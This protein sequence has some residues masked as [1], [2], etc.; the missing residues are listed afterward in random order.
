MYISPTERCHSM[1]TPQTKKLKYTHAQTKKKKRN[2]FTHTH[3][4]IASPPRH[5]I[6][7]RVTNFCKM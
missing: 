3:A 2:A 6:I 5:G 7:M 4:H 1:R